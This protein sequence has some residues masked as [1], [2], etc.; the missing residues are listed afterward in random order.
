MFGLVRDETGICWRQHPVNLRVYLGRESEKGTRNRISARNG[1]I[2]V[3]LDN[4]S[5]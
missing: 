5:E 3:V 4:N 1:R 2:Q